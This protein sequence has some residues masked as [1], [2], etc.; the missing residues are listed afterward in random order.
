[1]M[2]LYNMQKT[3]QLSRLLKYRSALTRLLLIRPITGQVDRSDRT[4]GQVT[5][6]NPAYC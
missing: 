2:F 5:D 6:W 3:E 1:M 4:Q